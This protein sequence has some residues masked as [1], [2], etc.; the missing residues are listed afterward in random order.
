MIIY[1]TCPL[2]GEEVNECRELRKGESVLFT[3]DDIICEGCRHD[4]SKVMDEA[5]DAVGDNDDWLN[6]YS[7]DNY[8]GDG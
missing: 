8:M 7:N 3:G 5:Y 2:C 6:Y 1:Y 4:D